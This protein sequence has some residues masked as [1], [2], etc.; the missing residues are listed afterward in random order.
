MKITLAVRTW[1]P[2]RPS[3]TQAFQASRVLRGYYEDSGE[4]A[5]PTHYKISQFAPAKPPAGTS[6]F[7]SNWAI[8]LGNPLARPRRRR[9]TG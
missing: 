7:P 4:D 6:Q 3:G 2:K 8:R 1:V 9:R 5:D